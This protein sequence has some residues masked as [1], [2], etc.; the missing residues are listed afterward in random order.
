MIFVYP[1]IVS[2]NVDSKI[3][4]AVC[5]A[6]EQYYLLNLAESFSS[7]N[8]RVKTTFDHSRGVY[9][10]LALENK[11]TFGMKVLTEGSLSRDDFYKLMDGAE[12]LTLEIDEFINKNPDIS[13][14]YNTGTLDKMDPSKFDSIIID[15]KHKIE[16]I[17]TMKEKFS[18]I[19]KV[20]NNSMF[21]HGITGDALHGL[22][23]DMSGKMNDLNKIRSSLDQTIKLVDR[24][25]SSQEKKEEKEEKDKQQDLGQY[26][27]HGNY[28]VEAMKGVSFKPTMMNINVKVHYA[29]GPHEEANTKITPKDTFQEISVGCKIAPMILK[30]FESIENAILDDYFSS[31][32]KSSWTITY[33]NMMRN[34]ISL[35]DRAMKKLGFGKIDLASKMGTVEKEVL[36]S[37]QGYVNA[38]SFKHKSD[39]PGFYNYSSAMVIMNKDDLTHEE[40]TNFFLNKSQLNRMFKLGWNSFCILDPTREEVI[41]ISSLDGGQMHIIPYSYI[42]H[43]LGMEQIFTDISDLQKRSPIFRR[44]SGNIN[45]LINKL[46]R[47]SVLLKMTRTLLRS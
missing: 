12:S 34:T 18:N 44:S 36:M 25:K 41:F 17:N 27:T 47:E 16:L 26:E 37:P 45:T 13:D 14:E 5:K 30:N 38:N 20:S 2:E 7:G 8:L 22:V 35:V 23:D 46:K 42:F 28:K 10:M 3:G 39:S 40:G 33:R 1:A 9:G 32:F 11:R 15:L 6:L 43:S 24:F 21:P 19:Q 29:G 4:P 31:Q